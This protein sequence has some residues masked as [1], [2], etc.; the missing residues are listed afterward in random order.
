LKSHR[1][2]TATFSLSCDFP[3]PGY[4]TV[5]ERRERKKGRESSREERAQGKRE[6]KGRE[7]SRETSDVHQ[8][9]WPSSSDPTLPYTSSD[10]AADVKILSVIT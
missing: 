1:H 6:L 9:L 3:G 2:S 7:S 4:I 8:G 10:H 5:G